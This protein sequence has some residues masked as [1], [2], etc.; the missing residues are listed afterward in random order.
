MTYGQ[1]PMML[2]KMGNSMNPSRHEQPM[3]EPNPSPE[4]IKAIAAI[5]GGAMGNQPQFENALFEQDMQRRSPNPNALTGGVVNPAAARPP[6]SEQGPGGADYLAALAETLSAMG[7]GR[8]PP[9]IEQGGGTLGTVGRG[10]DLV[11]NFW[12]KMHSGAKDAMR[13]Q[14]EPFNPMPPEDPYSLLPPN[15][16]LTPGPANYEIPQPQTGLY[17][18][19]TWADM[20]PR[21]RDDYATNFATVG[22]PRGSEWAGLERYLD[23][24]EGQQGAVRPSFAPG[25]ANYDSTTDTGFADAVAEGD[26]NK[27]VYKSLIGAGAK[28]GTGRPKKKGE[29]SDFFK[30]LKAA[31]SGNKDI[32]K[33]FK[34]LASQ[35]DAEGGEVPVS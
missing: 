19:D 25:A 20:S 17:G 5:L 10:A 11:G 21:A 26:P 3:R 23:S 16:S 8:T 33:S 6:S 2:A 32:K 31:K 27:D 35:L 4:L 7:A 24:P 28:P 29:Y 12:N 9:A 14:G 22:D 34:D 1:D 30:A 18:T 13:S 15:V